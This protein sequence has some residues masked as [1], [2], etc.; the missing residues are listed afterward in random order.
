MRFSLLW[1][2]CPT[3]QP[4]QVAFGAV[5]HLPKQIF[6]SSHISSQEEEKAIRVKQTRPRLLHRSKHDF[7]AILYGAS[8]H[9]HAKG[10]FRL[11]M[12]RQPLLNTRPVHHNIFLDYKTTSFLL[13]PDVFSSH[14]P[15]VQTNLYSLSS[16]CGFSW[17]REGGIMG[18]I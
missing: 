2:Y 17:A 5:K 9:N 18:K 4:F 8:K 15:V 16:W 14:I 1:H 10:T 6:F 3:N 13:S 7:C 11:H 12:I